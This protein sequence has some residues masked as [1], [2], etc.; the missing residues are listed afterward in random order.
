M[1]GIVGI[2]GHSPVAPL[3]VD[4]LKRLE[5]RGY[6]SAGI[7]T[8]EHGELGAPPRR[9]QADQS[10]APPDRRNRWRHDRHRPHPLGDPRRA[11]RDQ[12]ASAFLQWRRHRPQRHH[13]EFLR[14]C[15]TNS[16]RDGYEFA[17]QTDTEV[18]AHLVAREARARRHAGRCG[19]Q[20]AEAAG[21]RVRARHHVHAATT[22]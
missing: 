17:S 7:A 16:Q 22:T 14:I 1:C 11:Q 21:R 18:V 9:G 15:A 4:A 19:L 8:I 6:D 10:R 12:C 5:Y 13:R 3:I 2:V 20:R